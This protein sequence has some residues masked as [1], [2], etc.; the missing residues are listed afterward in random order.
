MLWSSGISKLEFLYAMADKVSSDVTCLY[1]VFGTK[2]RYAPSLQPFNHNRQ[3]KIKP[4]PNLA[5]ANFKFYFCKRQEVRPTTA[6]DHWGCGQYTLSVTLLHLNFPCAT[7]PV[8]SFWDY[9]RRVL[10]MRG[11]SLWQH[12]TISA[13]C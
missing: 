9:T 10:T 6:A 13:R 3:A 2:R 8:A 5:P 11:R 1:P 12:R 7:A 4:E